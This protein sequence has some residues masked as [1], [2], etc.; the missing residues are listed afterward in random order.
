MNLQKIMSQI[1][2]DEF[3]AEVAI[4]SDARLFFKFARRK[5]VVHSLLTEL[6]SEIAQNEIVKRVLN[7]LRQEYDPEYVRPSDVALAIYLW[8]LEYV[9]SP[10]ASL[11]ATDISSDTSFWW[12][13]QAAKII[14]GTQLD[15]V[16]ASQNIVNVQMP[17]QAFPSTSTETSE[18]TYIGLLVDASDGSIASNRAISIASKDTDAPPLSGDWASFFRLAS[19]NDVLQVQFI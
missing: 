9:R 5:R 8:A 6:Q 10:F 12:A 4:A 17:A 14:L 1:E 7:L 18:I 11:L 13:K 3:F 2:S 16:E 15:Y 19:F